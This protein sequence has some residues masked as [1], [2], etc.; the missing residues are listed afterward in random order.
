MIAVAEDVKALKG[1]D[2]ALY[3]VQKGADGPICRVGSIPAK[4]WKAFAPAA[5]AAA[6]N[7]L[8][9]SERGI[10]TPFYSIAFDDSGFFTS[11]YD[12][13]AGRE[14]LKAGKRGNV[15]KAY[16]DKPMN[17]DNWDIDIYYTEKSWLVDDV[18]SMEW[19]EQGPVRA[20]LRI[21]R[22][23]LHS[24]IV[25]NIRFYADSRNIDFDT[26]IDWKQHQVLLKAEFDFDLNANEATYDIQFGNLTRPTHDNT[27][28]DVAKFEVCAHKWADISESGYGA[29]ILNDCKY[30]YSAREGKMTLSLIKSGILPNPVTDQEEH[31]FTYALLPHMGSWREG[32]VPEAAYALNIPVRSVRVSAKGEGLAGQYAAVSAGN[33]ALETVKQALDGEDTILR[34]YEYRNCRGPVTVTLA[35]KAAHVWEC[36]MLENPIRELETDGHSFTFTIK[37]YEVMTFRVSAK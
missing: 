18:R 13:E 36:D 33:V 9:V 26:W 31:T 34:I 24:T 22:K 16:E 12:K 28:W 1:S 19:T 25:Q 10:E 37:P 6:D 30:G 14:L 35:D 2:G 15:L 21:E 5:E 8:T 29:A 3:P 11:I 7:R 17:Y 27:L 23:F 20:T 32:H 4:G